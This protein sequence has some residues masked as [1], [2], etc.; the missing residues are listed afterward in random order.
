MIESNQFLLTKEY[1]AKNI[2]EGKFPLLAARKTTPLYT[3]VKVN[4]KFA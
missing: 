4:V 2:R 1:R 3:P